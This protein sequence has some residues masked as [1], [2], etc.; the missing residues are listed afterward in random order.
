[1]MRAQVVAMAVRGAGAEEIARVVGFDRSH[2]YRIMKAHVDQGWDALQDHRHEVDRALA[3]EAFSEVVR[4]LVGG[5]PREYGYERATWTR[6]LLVRVS[7]G[8]TG[9]LVS[10]RTMSRVLRRVGARRGRPKPVVAPR[11]SPR[12][13]RRR[14]AG[15]RKIIQNLGPKEVCVYEDEVDIHLNPHVGW[16]WMLRG[17]Q[18]LLMTP[19]QNAKAYVAGALEPSTGR[20]TWVGGV[21]KTSELF[22]DLLHE[23]EK[24][25]SEATTIYVVLDNY[26]IHHSALTRAALKNLSKI[27]LVFLPPYSPDHNRIER[28]WQDL[29]ANVTR[30]HQYST[31]EDLCG[32]VARWLNA[33]S[34]WYC[35]QCPPTYLPLSA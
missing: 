15:I 18:K 13:Q 4:V 5:C 17:Q 26:G 34:Q 10:A 2:V 24:V 23:L 27:R 19:G 35:A 29:H 11:L 22:V 28:L 9:T 1:M 16:D 20:L 32:A 3:D 21:S 33:A 25:Y 30:N 12:Q 31:I 6:E 7:Y 8:M 14:L